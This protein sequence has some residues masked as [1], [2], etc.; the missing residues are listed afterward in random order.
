MDAEKNYRI[1]KAIS[2]TVAG[3]LISLGIN[4]LYKSSTMSADGRYA[5]ATLEFLG[6]TF[7]TGRLYTHER[8]VNQFNQLTA[9][10]LSI[11]RNMAETRTNLEATKASLEATTA[12]LTNYRKALET[13]LNQAQTFK[14]S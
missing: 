2:L 1:F 8:I 5:L 6:A 4:D 13:S 9:N 3:G 10:L 14:Q 12:H 11:G 7:L